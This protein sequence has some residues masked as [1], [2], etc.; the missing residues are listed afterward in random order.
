MAA[1]YS[2]EDHAISTEQLWELLDIVLALTERLVI[3]LDGLDELDLEDCKD[4]A[5]RFS[6]LS[7]K[8][9]TL[10]V[11]ILARNNSPG[12]PTSL[13]G[14]PWLN[15]HDLNMPCIE[16]YILGRI[17]EV[18]D[19]GL[20]N[21]F[22][23]TKEDVSHELA[24]KAN[25]VFM[26]ARLA[27]NSLSSKSLS[28]IERTELLEDGHSLGRDLN[29]LYDRILS[30]DIGQSEYHDRKLAIE[31]LSGIVVAQRKMHHKELNI[32]ISVGRRPGV[33]SPADPDGLF[34]YFAEHVAE[35]C[36]NLIEIDNAGI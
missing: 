36:C 4:T 24:R 21:T 32:A 34:L 16:T 9:T 2:P 33:K 17:S 13:V 20:V 5:I 19:A 35:V 26:W 6:Q 11:I 22:A 27:L 12:I 7:K 15:L 14:H 8:H 10:R 25:G 31:V 3:M 29:G 30:H 18:F 28:P 23:A 1:L